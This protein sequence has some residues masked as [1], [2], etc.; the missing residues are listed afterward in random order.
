MSP[1]VRLVTYPDDD[2]HF[3]EHAAITL[4]IDLPDSYAAGDIVAEIQRRLREAYPLA[5]IR[6]EPGDGDGVPPIWHVHRDGLTPA[7]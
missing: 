5:T 1:S 2:G 3:S 7:A 4:R 6:V